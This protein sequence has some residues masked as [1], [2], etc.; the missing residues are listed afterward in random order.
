MAGARRSGDAS[1][2]GDP[3]PGRPAARRVLPAL[4]CQA[5][6]VAWLTWPLPAKVATHL[7]DTTLA[8]RFDALLTAWAGAWE[9]NSLLH[10]P[11]RLLDA[12]VYHPAPHALLYAEMALGALALFLPAFAATGNA[13]LATNALLLGGTTLSAAALHAVVDHWTGSFVAGLLAAWTFL[14]TRWTLWEFVPTAPSYAVLFW[15]PAILALAA[16]RRRGAAGTVLLSLLLALQGLVSVVYLAAAALVPTGLLGLARAAR[17]STRADG[18]RL[19]AAVAGAALLLAPAW[20]ALLG[21]R[22]GNPDLAEQTF[23]RA[24]AAPARLPWGP[25]RD[26][27][28]PLAVPPAAMVLV[29]VG[30]ASALARGR[31][32]DRAR[33]W[34]HGALW[35]VAGCVL[36]LGTAVEWEGRTIATP[37]GLLARALPAL[38]AA[39]VPARMGVAGLF[40]FGVL[41]GAAFAELARR[42][43]ETLRSPRRAEV[44]RA[45]L[46]AAF[47]LAMFAHYR[48]GEG[49]ESQ[50][51]P[52]LP[53]AYP[54]FEALGPP[55]PVDAALAATGGPLLEMPVSSAIDQARAMFRSIRHRRPLLNGYSSY[56]PAGWLGRMELAA[57][58][59]DPEALAVLRRDAG[60]DAILLRTAELAPGEV[61]RW[62]ANQDL[63]VVARDD[64]AV[65]FAV[66]PRR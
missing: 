33:A 61:D 47:A 9:T 29:A 43:D 38:E 59:P 30:A 41:V 63:E 2:I 55:S 45:L 51:H 17:R 28:S 56:W 22:A 7:A 19:L 53:P 24:P 14:L 26:L 48:R 15:L 4:L 58:L 37:L 12:N 54:V 35:L 20:A 40:G 8:C 25:F 16:C 3:P 62:T 39:R 60:L 31:D 57:R 46:A 34:R 32:A 65:L 10:E 66:A 49:E 21:V 1:R 18:I 13:V 23:W 52:P 64:E 5:L 36:S 11:R 6:A 50:D 27:G 42:A 44:V